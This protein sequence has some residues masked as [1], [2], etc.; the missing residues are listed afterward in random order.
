MLLTP[1]LAPS[2]C[3]PHWHEL[4]QLDLAGHWLEH[5]TDPVRTKPNSRQCLEGAHY[6]YP[7]N[8]SLPTNPALLQVTHTHT[9]TQTPT[10][11]PSLLGLAHWT[12]TRS[13]CWGPEVSWTSACNK[14][15]RR[16]TLPLPFQTQDGF[17]DSWWNISTSSLVILAASVFEISCGQRQ[18]DKH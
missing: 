17:Q 4:K 8:C 11:S 16:K 1:W 10:N 12:I 5:H 14:K 13:Q 7:T 3:W 18:T 6:E 15:E 9:H 2:S